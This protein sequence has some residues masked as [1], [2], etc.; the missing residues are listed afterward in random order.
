MRQMSDSAYPMPAPP[1][2]GWRN[3]ILLYAGGDTVHPW[4][5]AEIAS[6]PSRY[7]WPCWVRSNPAQV[8][9]SLDAAQFISWLYAHRVPKG[10]CVILDLETAVDA[11]YVSVFN[12]ELR[13][14]GYKVTKYGSQNYIWE[15]PKT[16]GGTYVALPGPNVLSTE[17]DTV[18]RQYA[19]DGGYDLSI[20]EDQAVLPLW[21][22]RPPAPAGPPY[23]HYTDGT[24]KL[25]DIATSRNM[26]LESF[27]L[28]QGRQ[29]AA[30]T[31][32]L[33]ALEQAVP[34]KGIPW[35]TDSP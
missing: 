22:A 31:A 33:V 28:E 17:G 11:P 16:D 34:P 5:P 6:M 24:T 7:R 2:G 21:D 9:A 12:L 25:A 13:A 1:P 14:A 27:L 18:A 32:A 23:L 8:N 20:A 35:F 10:T 29:Y 15:N 30:Q 26:T 3:I 19:F 4:T